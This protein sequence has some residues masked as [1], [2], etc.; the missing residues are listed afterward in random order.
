M[1]CPKQPTARIAMKAPLPQ[2]SVKREKS[3]LDNIFRVRNT[4]W[5]R[6][7]VTQQRAPELIEE[8]NHFRLD[9][10]DGGHPLLG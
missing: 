3:L 4:Q 8:S 5:K 6:R 1:G 10:R 7:Q 2:V 9:R